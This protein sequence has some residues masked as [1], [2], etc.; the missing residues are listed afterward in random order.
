LLT[1]EQALAKTALALLNDCGVAL[2]PDN[3]EL[4]YTYSSGSNTEVGKVIDTLISARRPFTHDVLEDLRRRSLLSARSVDAIDNASASVMAT[5]SAVL[6][7]IEA[8]GRD[9]GDYG[10]TL[11][12]ASGELG[13]GRSPE[14]L[15]TFVDTLIVAT[16]VMEERAVVLEGELQRSSEEVTALRVQ[17]DDVRRESLTD[18]LTSV[19][20]RKAF[21][22]E[23]AVAL[24]EAQRTG[25]PVSLL[26]CDIDH[27]KK[28]NDTWGHQTGDQVLKL[29]AGNLSESVTDGDM[30]ARFG[31]EEFAIVLSQTALAR[32]TLLADQIRDHV[33]GKQLVKKSTGDILG[34]LTISIGVACSTEDDTPASLIQ[35]ADVC[36]YRAKNA[37]R[38]RVVNEDETSELQTDAAA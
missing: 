5:L 22:Q 2:T 8:A 14:Q 3:F 24:A 16:R 36:L 30:V 6:A 38:N 20:N 33:Q 29:V 9:A 13:D 35:R 27:F 19:A 18:S 10:R 21:D 34:M 17:L 12:R 37:G 31:G 26:L 15:R 11:S 7:K 23:L 4:F 32:A 28:F 1:R 25:R